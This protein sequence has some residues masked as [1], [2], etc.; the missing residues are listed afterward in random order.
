MIA[1]NITHSSEIIHIII[2]GV[3][4]IARSKKKKK[5]KKKNYDPFLK[6]CVNA[7]C[8]KALGANHYGRMPT[9]MI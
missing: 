9:N 7:V 3:P 2:A 6:H 1:Q 8:A 4:G 5:K